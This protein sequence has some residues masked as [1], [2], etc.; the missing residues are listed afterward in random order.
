[1]IEFRRV[2]A[3][4]KDMGHFINNNLLLKE[5]LQCLIF[6]YILQEAEGHQ[7]GDRNIF[8]RNVATSYSE[9]RGL[10]KIIS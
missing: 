10:E 3:R 2:D 5:E 4:S 1:M 9:T 6:V 7:L 8:A